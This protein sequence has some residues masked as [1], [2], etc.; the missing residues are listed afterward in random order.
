MTCQMP[1]IRTFRPED[2]ATV[3]RL[4]AAGQRDFSAGLEAEVEAYICL[5]LKADLS[6][7]QRHYLAVNGSHFWVAESM[8]EVVGMVGVQRLNREE[9]ELRRMSVASHARRQGIGQRLL[10]TVEGHCL[11]EGFSRMVLSTVTQ[12]QPA[13]AMYQKAGF[14]LDREEP[15]GSMTVKYYEKDLNG[16]TASPGGGQS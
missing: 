16:P 13:I 2:S 5:S 3:C 11:E 10:E 7:I 8:R 9:A 6:D 15:Y 4:F 12:L 14:R 1:T